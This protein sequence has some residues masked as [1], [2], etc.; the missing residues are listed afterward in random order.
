[1]H[2]IYRCNPKASHKPSEGKYSE[3]RS[4]KDFYIQNIT[5]SEHDNNIDCFQCFYEL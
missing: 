3:L 4:A 1:M 2:K 5:V